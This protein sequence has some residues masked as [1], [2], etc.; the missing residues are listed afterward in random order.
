MSK[1]KSLIS[2]M[3]KSVN[4]GGTV[5][6]TAELAYMLGET[7]T[8][9]FRKFI[10]DCVKSEVLVRVAQGLYISKVTPPDTGSILFDIAKKLRPNVF[11]YVSLESQLSHTGKIS[12]ILF[13]RLTI[14]TKGRKGLFE[15]PYGCIEFT[16]SKR[17]LLELEDK[18]YFDPEH[19][20]FRAT[21]AHAITDLKAC[22]RNL[23]ML[24]N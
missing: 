21:E 5:F 3:A 12:Q 14:M 24:D 16:H 10:S 4:H 23:H 22:G 11:S 2:A 7:V 8:A 6:D 19:K 15:T 20:I 18:V 17:D 13:D 1:S 9:R